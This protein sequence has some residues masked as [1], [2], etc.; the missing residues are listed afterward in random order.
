MF[1]TH[2]FKFLKHIL[3]WKALDRH[4]K[5]EGNNM[6]KIVNFEISA[7][8]SSSKYLVYSLTKWNRFQC[9][10]TENGYTEEKDIKGEWN[11]IVRV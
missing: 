4:F 8:W 10:Y 2:G 11:N 3:V 6:S 7:V 1:I 5:R 9:F